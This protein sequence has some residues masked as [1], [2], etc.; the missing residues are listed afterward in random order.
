MSRSPN[1]RGPARCRTRARSSRS[2]VS[3]ANPSTNAIE[4]QGPG[5][6]V[7]PQAREHPLQGPPGSQAASKGVPHPAEHPGA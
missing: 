1:R 3:R 6:E 4:V 7:P 2:G 5:S